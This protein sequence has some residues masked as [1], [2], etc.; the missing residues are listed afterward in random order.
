MWNFNFFLGSFGVPSSSLLED[1]R[2]VVI[3]VSVCVFI[4]IHVCILGRGKG[5]LFPF[6]PLVDNIFGSVDGFA[7]AGV[8]QDLCPG[9]NSNGDLHT[10]SVE[11]RRLANGLFLPE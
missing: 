11:G 9:I 4:F 5:E 1:E 7:S 2:P 6:S 8:S 10:L 3:R